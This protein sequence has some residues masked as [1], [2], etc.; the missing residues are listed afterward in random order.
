DGEKTGEAD[1]ARGYRKRGGEADLPDVEKTEPVAGTLRTVYLSEECIGTSGTREGG[2]ELSPYKAI[3]DGDDCAENPS[4]DREAV[5]GRG[6][7]QRQ[8]DERADTDHLQHVEE[9]GG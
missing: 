9:H 6:D 2:A 7:D 5:A 4:P 8:R 3:G 1:A